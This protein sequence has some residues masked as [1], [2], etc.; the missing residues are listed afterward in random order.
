[1]SARRSY[2]R[3]VPAPVPP[4]RFRMA[5]TL[6]ARCPNCRAVLRVP[7]AVAG[8]KIRCK[9]CQTV[10]TAAA[11]PAAPPPGKAAPVKAKPAEPPGDTFRM[12]DEPPKPGKAKPV[13]PASPAPEERLK[14]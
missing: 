3:P 2:S 11:G 1:M 5:E 6:Q 14:R 10:F 8:K 13:K 7:A 12:A 9:N 4:P